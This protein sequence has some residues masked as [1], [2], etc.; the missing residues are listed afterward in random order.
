M[1]LPPPFSF[2]LYHLLLVFPFSVFFFCVSF[3]Q[4]TVALA[5]GPAKVMFQVGR[6]PS[7][8]LAITPDN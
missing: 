4:L 1:L 6:T 7:P 5:D 3:I 8:H 2:S